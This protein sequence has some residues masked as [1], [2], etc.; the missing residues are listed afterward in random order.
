M[1]L[2]PAAFM[3]APS[4]AVAADP[5]KVDI[6]IERL[7]NM[8]GFV[9]IC[10]TSNP[11][12]FPDCGKDPAALKLSLPASAP[13]N[14]S[15]PAVLPGNYALALLHDENGNGR[16]DTFAMVPKEGFGFSNNPKIR[17]GAPRF[18]ETRFAVGVG[19]TR[20]TIRMRY[21]L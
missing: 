18:A 15:F 21:L 12:S 20:Q 13:M 2:L 5:G 19:T 1:L 4:S 16:M 10:L 3:L 17:F 14:V 11:A 6:R 7:R 9:R 8:R